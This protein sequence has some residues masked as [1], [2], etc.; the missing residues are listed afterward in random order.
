MKLLHFSGA[1][2]VAH[3]MMLIN[4]QRPIKVLYRLKKG[5]WMIA[6]SLFIIFIIPNNYIYSRQMYIKSYDLYIVK[7]KTVVGCNN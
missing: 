6:F 4:P 3:A 7:D 5:L 1:S 2:L